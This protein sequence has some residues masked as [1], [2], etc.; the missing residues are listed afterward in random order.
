MFIGPLH[1]NLRLLDLHIMSILKSGEDFARRLPREHSNERAKRIVIPEV[2]RRLRV[3]RSGRRKASSASA[4]SV[5]SFGHDTP[6]HVERRF[7]VRGRSCGNERAALSAAP[8]A[9]CLLSSAEDVFGA[10]I[11]RHHSQRDP[12]QF[13]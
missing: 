1:P 5:S 13:V 10:A 7:V 12:N 11:A 3:A 8:N 2:R 9:L 4:S 6:A